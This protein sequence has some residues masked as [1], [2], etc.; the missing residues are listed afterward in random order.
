MQ[1]ENLFQVFSQV[2]IQ[3]QQSFNKCDVELRTKCR[4]LAEKLNKVVDELEKDPFLADLNLISTLEEDTLHIL[5]STSE[6][7]SRREHIK[8]SVRSLQDSTQIKI[9]RRN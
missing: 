3:S 2:F 7:E 6:L 4:T 8:E 1:S 9:G 5:R